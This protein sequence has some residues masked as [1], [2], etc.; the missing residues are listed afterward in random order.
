[1]F[2]HV[3]CCDIVPSLV[4]SFGESLDIGLY[5]APQLPRGFDHFYGAGRGGEPPPPHSAGRGGEPPLPAGRVPCGAGRPSLPSALQNSTSGQIRAPS[6]GRERVESGF[7]SQPSREN[8]T[9]TAA[10]GLLLRPPHSCAICTT[11]SLH[12]TVLQW[13]AAH[14][15]LLFMVEKLMLGTIA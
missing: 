13:R 12:C 5:F 6:I 3:Q 8:S 14:I 10:A 4:S 2:T 9:W 11:L 7:V 15:C 1:M